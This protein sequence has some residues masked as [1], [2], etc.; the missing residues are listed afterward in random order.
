MSEDVSEDDEEHDALD[1]L[2]PYGPDFT[3]AT[4]G[5]RIGEDKVLPWLLE[6]ASTS[7]HRATLQ[8]AIADRCLTHITDARNR[9]DMARHVVQALQAYQLILVDDLDQVRLTGV[10]AQILAEPGRT[11]DEVFGQHIL[12]M[13]NGYRLVEAIH[14]I[15]LSGQRVELEQLSQELDRSAT[16]KNLSTMKAWLERAGVMERGRRYAIRD[17]R[18]EEL[19]GRGAVKLLELDEREVEFLLAARVQMT[20]QKDQALE[21]A[22]VKALAETRRPDVKL[23]SKGLASFARGLVTKRLIVEEK[24]ARSKGGTRFAFRVSSEGLKLTD[25][26]VRKLVEQSWAGMPLEKLRPIGD[27]LDALANGTTEERGQLGEMLAVHACLIL[28]LR[29][30]A[31]RKRA[32][33][34]IDLSAERTVGLSYQRWHLQVKNIDGDLGSD[35]VDREIGAAVGTGATHL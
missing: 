7:G 8:A 3:P 2:V 30:V 31:W 10:G 17:A 32:P 33:V 34:E 24:K 26:Q 35:R 29:V 15:E 11:R 14:R 16:S 28:G 12:T 21:A 23:P 22:D 27:A 1:G 5:K 6:R 9:R 19:L 13:C 25:E 18:V 4:L 20:L